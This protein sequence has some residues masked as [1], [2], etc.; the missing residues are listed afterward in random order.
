MTEHPTDDLGLYALG[1]LDEN[2]RRSIERHLAD[3]AVCTAEL[4][5]YRSTVA[6]LADTTTPTPSG[7]RESIVAR[8]RAPRIAGTRFGLP[9]FAY[10]ASIV[11]TLALVA[12]LVV[13]SQERTTRD[14][15]AR[16]LAAVASGARVVPLDA[17]GGASARGSVV[18]S[19][20]GPAY[21]VLQLPASPP[22][23]GWE[24]WIIRDGVAI[25]A[26][27]AP[28]GTGVITMQLHEAL[29]AGDRAA[30][31]LEDAAGSRAPTS[32]PVLLGQV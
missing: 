29:R 28:S 1:L 14:E 25:P 16:T 15:Y 4:A 9:V 6:A 11:L 31:T 23:K 18:V 12:S 32:T 3:C 8:H 19:R 27:M 2:E 7:L 17:Q 26:G 5:S 10:A 13:L 22:G 21:L 20:E 30:L 24:A